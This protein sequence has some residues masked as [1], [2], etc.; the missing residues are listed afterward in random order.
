MCWSYE[1]SLFTGLFS[2]V[3]AGLLYRRDKNYD[4]WLAMFI[5]VF[6][7][8]QWLEAILWKNTGIN[9]INYYITKYAIPFVLSIEGITALYGASLYKPVPTELFVIYFVYTVLIFYLC[10]NNFNYTKISTNN[11][12]WTQQ[13]NILIGAIYAV[14]LALPF[15]L[16]MDGITKY[17]IVGGIIGTLL[18]SIILYQHAWHSNW[19][20]FANIVNIVLL[21]T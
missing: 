1:V 5:F 7:T 10:M 13:Q 6:S 8:I 14:F 12:Q 19:C 20:F 11:L 9:N 2:Y 3:V 18:Y 16:Y 4:K 21:L 17:I 15:V